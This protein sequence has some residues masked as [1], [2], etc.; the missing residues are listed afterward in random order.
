M[1]TLAATLAALPALG[2]ASAQAEEV[3]CPIFIPEAP[4]KYCI[5]VTGSGCVVVHVSSAGGSRTIVTCPA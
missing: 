4:A 2:T 5:I 1:L 3:L